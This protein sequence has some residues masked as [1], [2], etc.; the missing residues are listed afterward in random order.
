MYFT[1]LELKHK[2]NNALYL[3]GIPLITRII[4]EI[5][6]V[7]LWLKTTE[8]QSKRF[9]LFH[10]CVDGR[11]SKIRSQFVLAS[12]AYIPY[13]ATWK[14]G[15]VQQHFNNYTLYL[16][17]TIDFIFYRMHMSSKGGYCLCT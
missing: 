12:G 2:V 4:A 8:F 3:L 10:L 1:M 13:T 11:F 6:S 9:L 17:Y 5:H 7:A 14:H 16:S 15:C